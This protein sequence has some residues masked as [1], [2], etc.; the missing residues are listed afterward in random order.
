RLRLPGAG[1]AA[2]VRRSPS[3]GRL[4]G[5]RLAAGGHRHPRGRRPDHPQHQPLRAAP[6]PIRT[7]S[8]PMIY[9][10]TPPYFA[11]SL[12]RPLA[13]LLVFIFL[14]MRITPHPEFELIAKGNNATAIALAG[15]LLGFVIPLASSII[16]SRN[17]P[18]MLVWGVV[19]MV[20]QI[21]IVLVIKAMAPQLYARGDD[22][23][24]PTAVLPP[25]RSLC[26]SILK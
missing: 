15:A 16:Q 8:P 7:G 10:S 11:A 2:P 9:L 23:Q 24:T 20:V 14:Y 1:T 25:S 4:V 3:G 21:A 26:I 19:A 18:D 12:A 13:L 6:L 17:I 22:G 5:H